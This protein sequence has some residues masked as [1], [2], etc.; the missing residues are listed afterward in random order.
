[1]NN[2]IMKMYSSSNYMVVN[3]DLAKQIGLTQS[4]VF[5][6]LCSLQDKL[7]DN[8]F[9]TQDKIA[10]ACCISVSTLKRSLANL[11]KLGYVKTTKKGIPC[12]TFYSIQWSN[13][14]VQ[15]EPTVESKMNQQCSPKWTNIIS[16]KYINKKCINTKS[17]VQFTEPIID[18]SNET[19]S[20]SKLSLHESKEMFDK[21]WKA[22][23]KSTKVSKC[24]YAF[25]QRC[26]D[27]ET[28]NLMMAAIEDQKKTIW[29]N[30]EARFI[31]ELYKWL[32]DERW[33][34]DVKNFNTSNNQKTIGNS[35]KWDKV[36]RDEINK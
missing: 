30:T 2:S 31:P 7:G 11:I 24:L 21:I 10:D 13:L 23:P 33:M 15:N 3:R 28:F 6:Q 32:E 5:G 9:F 4:I 35:D 20:P 17:E 26:F 16:N 14:I 25:R 22:Y 8:F 27:I 12:Q 36:A 1:M 34:D 29:I 19:N 18:D